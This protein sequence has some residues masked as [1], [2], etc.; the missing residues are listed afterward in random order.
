[1][2]H[3]TQLR[4]KVHMWEDE[5]VCEW[6][7]RE[8]TNFLFTLLVHQMLGNQMKE[9]THMYTHKLWGKKIIGWWESES[10]LG[11]YTLLQEHT[12]HTHTDRLEQLF[13]S[14]LDFIER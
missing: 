7:S 12:T 4:W 5:Y 10:W 6:L 8:S 2:L 11:V 9:G 13:S 14:W 3:V 1:M